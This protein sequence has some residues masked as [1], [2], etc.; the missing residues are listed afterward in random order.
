MKRK[1]IQIFLVIAASVF[2]LVFPAYFCCSNSA[3]VKLL[4]TDL[5][6]ENPDQDDIFSY[7]NNQLKAFVSSVFTIKLLPEAILFDQTSRFLLLASFPDHKA[8][9]LRC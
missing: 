3:G 7:Q 2:I 6:F 8:S 1:P 5:S 4:S 9:I